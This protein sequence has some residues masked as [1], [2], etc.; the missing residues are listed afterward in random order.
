[1]INEHRTKLK[2]N[3]P[4]N[5]HKL[6][7]QKVPTITTVSFHISHCTMHTSIPIP[8]PIHNSSNILF[9]AHTHDHFY[10]YM[11]TK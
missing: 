3:T 8:I 4:T 11:N 7:K 2:D 9:F 6:Y 1:M 5:L 10:Q